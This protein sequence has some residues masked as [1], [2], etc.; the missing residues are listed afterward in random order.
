MNLLL[1]DNDAQAVVLN[2]SPYTKGTSTAPINTVTSNDASDPVA[3]KNELNVL[4]GPLTKVKLPAQASNAENDTVTFANKTNH[5]ITV[6]TNPTTGT[7]SDSYK[8]HPGGVVS[9]GYTAGDW[10]RI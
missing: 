2:Q 5:D 1:A 4:A 3:N 9:Y 10:M 6:R 7:G 8:L